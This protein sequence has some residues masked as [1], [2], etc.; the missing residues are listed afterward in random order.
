MITLGGR[1]FAVNLSHV[2]E[3]FK[4][5]SITPV[6]GMPATLVGVANLR[7]IIIPLADL[8]STL[9]TSISAVQKYAVIVR[10]GAQQVGILIDEVPEIRTIDIDDLSAPSVQ[11]AAVDHP[12]LSGF[13]KTETNVRGMLEVSRLLASVEEARG[14]TRALVQAKN[15]GNE[16]V[17]GT[18]S[19]PGR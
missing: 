14:D 13:F 4:L 9:G 16:G 2:R 1:S 11:D 17:T 15:V 5:E 3:V 19:Y 10:H 18:G 12:F 6:P 8:R 7:G